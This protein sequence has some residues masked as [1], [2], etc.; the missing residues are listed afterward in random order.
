MEG[1]LFGNSATAARMQ[2][3]KSIFFPY[4]Y[5]FGLM[6]FQLPRILSPFSALPELVGHS[7]ASNAFLFRADAGLLYI[8]GTLNQLDNPKH[9]FQV[10]LNLLNIVNNSTGE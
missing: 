5:G 1:V 4:K 6:R 7:K 10:I 3:W 2:Q 8:A 9:P